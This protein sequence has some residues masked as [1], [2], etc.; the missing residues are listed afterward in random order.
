LH[1]PTKILVCA[2]ITLVTALGVAAPASADPSVFGVLSCSCAETV[3]VDNAP[4]ID[5]IQQGL[6]TGLS[7]LRRVPA[8]Q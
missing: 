3:S 7:D 8:Q 4:G 5:P 6:Q 1:L 2:A